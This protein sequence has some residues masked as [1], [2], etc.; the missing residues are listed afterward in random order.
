MKTYLALG[1]SVALALSSVSSAF[2]GGKKVPV[3]PRDA[4]RAANAKTEHPNGRQGW[5]DIDPNCNGSNKALELARQG[6]IKF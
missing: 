5:C 2:A 1:L 6:K 3:D 4:Y